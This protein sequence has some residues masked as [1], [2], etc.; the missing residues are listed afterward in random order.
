M[1]N[2]IH[3]ILT[4]IVTNLIKSFIICIRV[5]LRFFLSFFSTHAKLNIHIFLTTNNNINR[6][7]LGMFQLYYKKK[8]SRTYINI[9]KHI[10]SKLKIIKYSPSQLLSS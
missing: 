5:F 8:F 7:I 1:F 4:L 3:L 10:K 6:N 2:I 9:T